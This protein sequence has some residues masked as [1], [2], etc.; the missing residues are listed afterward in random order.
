MGTEAVGMG[1][2]FT[3]TLQ[4]CNTYIIPPLH[5]QHSDDSFD[6]VKYEISSHLLVTHTK[7]RKYVT[8]TMHIHTHTGIYTCITNRHSNIFVRHTELIIK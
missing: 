8:F 2:V 7:I 6:A 4:C 1:T 5:N 3:G